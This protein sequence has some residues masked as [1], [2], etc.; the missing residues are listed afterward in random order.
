LITFIIFLYTLALIDD[1]YSLRATP[2]SSLLTSLP[3][4]KSFSH[5]EEMKVLGEENMN[6][7]NITDNDDINNL[8][9]K[10]RNFITTAKNYKTSDLVEPL[11][12][13]LHHDPKLGIIIIIQ[14]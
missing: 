2:T 4:D 6:Q 8:I 3:R 11:R 14:N 5:V 12:V 1:G 9:K 10:H 7:F 13:L